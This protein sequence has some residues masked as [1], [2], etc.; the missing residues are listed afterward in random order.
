MAQYTS[1]YGLQLPDATDYYDVS[2]FNENFIAL[3]ASVKGSGIAGAVSLLRE[4]YDGMSA[5]DAGTIYYVEETDG[6][7]RQYKGDT[8]ISGGSEG[9]V[10]VVDA[11][12]LADGGIYGM[13][14]NAE[15][16]ELEVS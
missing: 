8:L 11:M 16:E 1:K 6:K 5:H 12:L 4:A 9:G 2:V 13:V 7:I 3:E 15:Y 10:G 14:V